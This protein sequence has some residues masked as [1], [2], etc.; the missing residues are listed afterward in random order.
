MVVT[1][2]AH[3]HLR[4]SRTMTSPRPAGPPLSL[5]L[6]L[7]P[8]A[9]PSHHHHP[10]STPPS[11]PPRPS[12]LPAPTS[13]KAQSPEKPHTTYQAYLLLNKKPSSSYEEKLPLVKKLFSM[14]LDR[15]GF[16]RSLHIGGK[17]RDT[18]LS[19]CSG[20]AL[21]SVSLPIRQSY[22]RHRW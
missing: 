5:Y 11:T 6:L 4:S 2:L 20:R 3:T 7:P 22:V 9:P 19:K 18:D 12:K 15:G 1:F 14:F 8:S 21:G 13:M 16:R 10:N 17:R